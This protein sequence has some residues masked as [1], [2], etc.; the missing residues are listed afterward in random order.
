MQPIEGPATEK[1]YDHIIVAP[2]SVSRT[3]PVP[4]LREHGIGFKPSAKPSSCTT[5]STPDPAVR[6]ASLTFVF[7]GGGFAGLG[8]YKGVANVYG[9]KV[10]GLPPGSCTGP[11]T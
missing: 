2:G 5:T 9:I 1:G 7:V 8:S 3:L 10:K 11:T 4:G 6:K